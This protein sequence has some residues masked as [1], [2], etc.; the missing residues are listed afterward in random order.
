MVQG[1][2]QTFLVR[3]PFAYIMT[4]NQAGLFMIGLASPLASTFG[5]ILNLIYLSWFRKHV[6]H[7]HNTV[8]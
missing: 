2:L 5:A 6:L 4:I 3:V 8:E 7:G 1:I